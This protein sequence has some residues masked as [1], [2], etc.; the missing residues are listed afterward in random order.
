MLSGSEWDNDN[1]AHEEPDE[2]Y[3][4]HLKGQMMYMNE[5]QSIIFLGTP[6]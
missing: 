2:G 5:W 4:I 6:M 3:A 1:N